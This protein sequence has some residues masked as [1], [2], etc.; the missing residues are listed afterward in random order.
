[1]YSV[2]SGTS[3]K[4]KDLLR[5]RVVN[6]FFGTIKWRIVSSLGIVLPALQCN[7]SSYALLRLPIDA[8]MSDSAEIWRSLTS[9][10]RSLD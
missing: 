3:L 7:Y 6:P 9:R 4:W 1:M 8:L 2:D 5:S 10:G